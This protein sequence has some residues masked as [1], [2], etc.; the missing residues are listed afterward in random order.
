MAA[1]EALR[2]VPV[3]PAHAEDGLR[4][5]AEAGWNQTS[6]DWSLMLETGEGIGQLTAD[7]ELVASAV[8]LPYGGR[9]AWIGMVLTSETFRRRGLATAN[10]RWAIR[11][12]EELGLI[13]G[14]D[15]TPTGREVYRPLGFE[16]V[17]GLTRFKSEAPVASA[18]APE[19]VT[20]RP[21]LVDDLDRVAE[22]DADAF[23][24][25]RRHLVAYLRRAAPESGWIAE[26]R[27]RLE[28]FVL[29][30]PGRLA[31]HIGPLCAA[32]VGIAKALLARALGDRQE[33]ASIDVP[34][35]QSAFAAW[36]EECNFV[37]IRPFTRMLK[38]A[39]SVPGDPRRLF[40]I[41]GPELG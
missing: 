34:D 6:P 12:C 11:R 19:G 20:L 40:A 35:D 38:G 29:G 41:A 36:V 31:R 39:S 21:M 22:A 5:S 17:F 3:S 7:G 8:I 9:L 28:G 16:G 32:D 10:L 24:A 15:A 18:S 14:L 27:S 33:P 23:G 25:E 1:T 13:A 4:L 2:T 26:R 37:R 30:R